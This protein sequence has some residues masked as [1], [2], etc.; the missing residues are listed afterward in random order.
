MPSIFSRFADIVN[1]NLNAML[2]KAENPAKMVR[3]VIAEMED[4]LVEIKAACAQAMAD[5]AQSDRRLQE[6]QGKMQLWQ[7]RAETATRKGRDDLAREALLERRSVAVLVSEL[8]NREV[9]MAAVVEK[10]RS[11][12][13]QLEAKLT[14][15]RERELVL[16]HR[17][18]RA[19][20]SLKASGQMKRYD[21]SESRLKLDRLDDR[22]NKLEAA[23]ELEL[24]GRRRSAEAEQRERAFQELDEALDL[25][26]QEIKDR[27][28][29]R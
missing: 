21:L 6:A 24:T 12:I 13:G 11:E 29:S 16:V 15:A 5:Q 28:A 4:T 3:L 19:A 27:L 7:A 1:S 26:L 10:Y 14:Q 20:N 17:E 2:D 18:K 9:E 22:L 25:E 8:T 23:A